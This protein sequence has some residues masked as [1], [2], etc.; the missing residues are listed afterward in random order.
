MTV[1][2]GYRLTRALRTSKLAAWAVAVLMGLTA[3]WQA[4]RLAS[5]FGA[6]R[7][8]ASP[9]G[10]MAAASARAEEPPPAAIRDFAVI[11]ETMDPEPP[12][13]APPSAE[14]K[15]AEA[16]KPPPDPYPE[17][18]LLGTITEEGRAYALLQIRQGLTVLVRQGEA[19]G[20]VRLVEVSE[21][22]ATVSL[23]DRT[24]T[25]RIERE[26]RE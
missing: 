18:R 26:D 11:W 6:V 16:P 19:A 14:A 17:M 3:A 2:K 24:K 22:E 25:L 10:T 15:P 21:N 1:L 4:A 5:A 13:P 12:K 23:P 7:E 9:E 8:A 20:D